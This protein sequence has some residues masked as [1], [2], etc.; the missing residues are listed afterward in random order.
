MNW[1][2]SY[3]SMES[4][5]KCIWILHFLW[6]TIGTTEEKSR[7]QV[8]VCVFPPPDG[9]PWSV[10]RTTGTRSRDA[11][12]EARAEESIYE[13][14][15]HKR[16]FYNGSE[17]TQEDFIWAWAIWLSH[18][19]MKTAH[20]VSSGIQSFIKKDQNI[21]I[22]FRIAFAGEPL[23]DRG[24]EQGLLR[25][26]LPRTAGPGHQAEELGVQAGSGLVTLPLQTILAAAPSP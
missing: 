9:S 23:L 14:K 1:R 24:R 21:R 17:R 13:V 2:P 15:C 5:M 4:M 20:L 19:N 18:L 26:Q 22:V 3:Q 10:V 25:L 7:V 16:E 11:G 12:G 8:N 6:Q